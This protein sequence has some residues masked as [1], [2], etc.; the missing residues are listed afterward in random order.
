M[1]K[2]SILG[3]ILIC[4]V[5]IS[6]FLSYTVW[7]DI[8]GRIA[9]KDLQE[10]KIWELDTVISPDKIIVH[11]GNSTHTCIYPASYL[12][13]KI[14]NY[15]KEMYISNWANSNP[16]PVESIDLDFFIQKKGIEIYFPTS[17]P[18][19]FLKQLLNIKGQEQSTLDSISISSF[20]MIEDKGLSGYIKDS[21]GNFY[22]LDKI[23]ETKEMEK[24]IDEIANSSPPLYAIIPSGSVTLK[25][26]KGIYVPISTCDMP[27]YTLKSERFNY[28]KLVPKFFPDFSVT[29]KI[30]ER[31]GAIIYTDGKRALRIYPYGAM[32]YSNPGA[33]EQK[34]KS[35]FYEALNTAVDFINA[36]GGWPNSAYL[37]QYIISGDDSDR[38]SYT[39][40]FKM[41]VDGFPVIND[42]NHLTVT[43]EGN[44][45][46]NYQR[47]FKIIDKQLQK[48]DLISPIDA[49]NLAVSRKNINNIE[50]IYCAYIISDE[51]LNP[52]WVI[53]TVREDI[54]IDAINGIEVN[55]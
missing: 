29:R 37:A 5:G 49:L 22:K 52:V 33:I 34:K 11:L 13:N 44:T 46:K 10:G 31:D 38:L 20:L 30:E 54:L 32:E 42:E 47:Q 15:S 14:L 16:K 3:W 19:S 53:K 18:M 23:S 9:G 48:T 25:I 51:K 24:L 26:A 17:L 39:F 55:K 8:P 2:D 35:S 41:K 12:Y 7:S 1:T 36:H 21:K 27:T 28:T 4:L 43:V 6:L 45:V 40:K 50:N